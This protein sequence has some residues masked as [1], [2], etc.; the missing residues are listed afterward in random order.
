MYV[1]VAEFDNPA[2][3]GLLVSTLV[4][5]GFHPAPLAQSAHVQVAGVARVFTVEV[6]PE[7]RAD[8]IQFLRENG[9]SKNVVS[10]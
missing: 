5:V 3:A 2:I 9:Y 4:D 6:P 1:A 7:E 8:V 10:L